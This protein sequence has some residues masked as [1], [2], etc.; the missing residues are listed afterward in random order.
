MSFFKNAPG[1]GLKLLSA[2]A[3]KIERIAVA[4]VV[5]LEAEAIYALLNPEADLFQAYLGG[6]TFKVVKSMK[7][8]TGSE[9][10]LLGSVFFPFLKLC[11]VDPSTIANL[12]VNLTICV[13]AASSLESWDDASNI[14][15]QKI[16]K[17]FRASLTQ[18]TGTTAAGVSK[19]YLNGQ[20]QRAQSQAFVKPSLS[21]PPIP[22]VSSLPSLT[23]LS[24]SIV[25]PNSPGMITDPSRSYTGLP[26][27]LDQVAASIVSVFNLTKLAVV[28]PSAYSLSLDGTIL[29][30]E[31]GA[32][33][34]GDKIG[35]TYYLAPYTYYV[36]GLAVVANYPFCQ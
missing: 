7:F 16:S 22:T 20:I 10:A 13:Y 27:S 36:L 12:D 33:A 15:L 23:S 17:Q 11:G 3:T 34:N 29:I 1:K 18:V 14:S 9:F 25:P 32:V 4:D 31:T 6:S 35:V 28:Q 2:Y 24:P 30:I 8:A 21:I 19:N 5:Q 26:I